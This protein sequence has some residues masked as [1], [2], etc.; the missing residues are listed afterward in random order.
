[1]SQN[2]FQVREIYK[3]GLVLEK[4]APDA[5]LV[6]AYLTMTKG[7]YLTTK[8]R[9]IIEEAIALELRSAQYLVARMRKQRIM[10][11]NHLQNTAFSNQKQPIPSNSRFYSEWD[12][13]MWL[14]DERLKK[15]AAEK[16]K[17]SS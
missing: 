3:G 10:Q 16:K 17:Q 2:I 12:H 14:R 4:Y 7:I 13:Q 11:L 8:D 5:V 9:L 1:M 15:E 6:F